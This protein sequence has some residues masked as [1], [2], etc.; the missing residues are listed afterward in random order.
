MKM[1]NLKQKVVFISTNSIY[2]GS[3]VLMLKTAKLLSEFLEI[4]V[5]T[6]Y[7]C[8]QLRIK[9][10]NINF[11]YPL[12]KQTFLNR[13]KNKFLNKT[14]DFKL[15]LIKIKPS[16][17]IISQGSP[18][19]SLNE[20]EICIQLNIKFIVINQ[21]VCEFHWSQIY[22]SLYLRFQNAYSHANT[23]YFVSNQNEELFKML[24]GPIFSSKQINNPLS[25]DNCDYLEFPDTNVFK[26][27]FVGRIEF[28]HKG[29]DLLI[30][31]L[32]NP[33]WKKRNIQF[34][35]YGEGPHKLLLLDLIDRYELNFCIL[36][37]HTNDL[38]KVWNENHLAIL[39]SRFEGKSLSISEAMSVGRGV[40]ATNVGGVE[41]Q[42]EDNKSGFICPSF[43]V[44]SLSETLERAWENRNDWKEIGKNARV[45]FI[46]DNQILPEKLLSNE[47]EN[48]IRI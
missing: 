22:D 48:I 13:L 43:T 2:S 7:N 44:E 19:A 17:V 5:F 10:S 16:L 25:I 28:F 15:N 6:K 27:A 37:E 11:L 36:N 21:L 8:N 26:I 18:L 23:I 39:P 42:I 40:I 12:K 45:K 9:N 14:V 30:Q 32:K 33:N 35:F 3:E 38:I 24:F 41:E 34:N 4:F 46:K 47:I 31:V 29:L 1:D 20:M